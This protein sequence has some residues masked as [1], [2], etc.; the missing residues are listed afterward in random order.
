VTDEGKPEYIL[1]AD[2]AKLSENAGWVALK[3][4]HLTFFKK[5]KEE[6]SG[7]LLADSGLYYFR[8]VPRRKRKRNDIDLKGNVVFHTADGTT[9]KTPEVHYTGESGKIYSDAGFEKRRISKEQTIIITGR[10]F[11]TDKN[12][13]HWEDTGA[14]MSFESHKGAIEKEK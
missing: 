4:I 9:L 12:L 3:K 6:K 11:V 10:S 5:A 8:D 1:R 7:T 2:V 14:Q 13:R